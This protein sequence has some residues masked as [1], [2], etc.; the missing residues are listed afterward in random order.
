MRQVMKMWVMGAAGGKNG[1]LLYFFL[2]EPSPGQKHQCI[3]SY[4]LFLTDP[5]FRS[6]QFHTIDASS[7]N[8]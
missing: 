3:I 5:S 6:V 8:H 7:F 4:Q 1:S 2:D